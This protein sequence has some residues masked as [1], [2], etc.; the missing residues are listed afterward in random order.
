M[1]YIK[2]LD[3]N[4]KLDSDQNPVGYKENL[5]VPI[6]VRGETVSSIEFSPLQIAHFTLYDVGDGFYGIGLV[7]PLY[8]TSLARM[9]IEDGLSESIHRI[10]FPL[11][12]IR[13]GDDKHEPTTTELQHA[14]DLGSQLSY[15]H[16]ASFPRWMEPTILETR[17]PARFGENLKYY[18]DMEIAGL[19]I[20]RAFVIGSGEET[21]KATLAVQSIM[22]ER[23]IKRMQN[24]IS[25]VIEQD[26]FARIA[27][28]KKF[29]D[30]PK[31]IWNP[32]S[33]DEMNSF[34]DRL[35]TYSDARVLSPTREL[36]DYVR[37]LEDLPVYVE[38]PEDK[39]KK[40]QIDEKKEEKIEDIEK[41]EKAEKVRDGA[42]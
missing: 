39:N 32:I 42:E 36:E 21:N 18:I 23:T 5:P 27:E 38:P 6:E 24:R 37:D 9:N 11:V 29:K 17:K 15:S 26:I 25:Y 40:E 8:K 10:G 7:E 19:G 4:M 41:T 22:F 34:A 28:L 14:V 20:P 33:L 30:F 12:I 31:I 13:V 2:L 1:D 35:K 3:G 16:V